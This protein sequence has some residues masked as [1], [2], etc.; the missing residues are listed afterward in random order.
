MTHGLA[1]RLG[2]WLGCWIVGLSEKFKRH[3][4]KGAAARVQHGNVNISVVAVPLWS[5]QITTFIDEW[6]F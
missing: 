6:E 1:K 4:I 3:T 2:A 5:Y